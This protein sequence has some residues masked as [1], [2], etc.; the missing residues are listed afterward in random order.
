M[1][2]TSAQEVILHTD[3]LRSWAAIYTPPSQPRLYSQAARVLVDMPDPVLISQEGWL[4]LLCF[5]F[6]FFKATVHYSNAPPKSIFT[7]STSTVVRFTSQKNKHSMHLCGQALSPDSPQGTVF[8]SQHICSRYKIKN[9]QRHS[10]L[11]DARDPSTE[12]AWLLP[13]DTAA[14][15]TQ[16]PIQ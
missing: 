6:F 12:Q 11:V 7:H 3:T 5:C 8:L 2:S 15:G 1:P 13:R 10:L 16:I 14:S 4:L 9:L